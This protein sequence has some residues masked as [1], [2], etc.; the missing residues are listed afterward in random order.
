MDVGSSIQQYP[1]GTTTT[2]INSNVLM[3][4]SI[5][6]ASDAQQAFSSSSTPNP[7]KCT[8]GLGED[9]CGVEESLKQKLIF[10]LHPI[11]QCG[12]GEA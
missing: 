9:A 2:C 8:P 3:P 5:Q 6:H 10:V 11:P 7:A 4:D 1:P 12:N